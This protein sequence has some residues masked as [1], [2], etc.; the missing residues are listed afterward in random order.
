MKRKS[1]IGLILAI[2]F[3]FIASGCA[4]KID[5]STNE[6]FKASLEKVRQSLPESERGKLDDAIKYQAAIY[7]KDNVGTLLAVGVA[8]VLTDGESDTV[9]DVVDIKSREFLMKF[10]GKT[11]KEI[12]KEYE[13]LK[14]KPFF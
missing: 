4:P 13:A 7:A 2:L 11:G 3:L 10:D 1:I 12:I 5:A 8:A 9:K 6:S 14:D